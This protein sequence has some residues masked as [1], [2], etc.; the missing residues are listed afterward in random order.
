MFNEFKQFLLRGN[1]V[2]MGVGV[3]M[4]VAFKSVVDG[5]VKDMITP[6]IAAVAGEADFSALLF[7]LNGSQFLYGHLINVVVSF[8]ITAVVVFYLV[9]KPMNHF[10]VRYRDE[11]VPTAPTMHKCSFCRQEIAIAATRCPFCT[12]EV[13][14]AA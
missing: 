11:E 14:T 10:M 5:L 1:V 9:V 13:A 6:M 7:T 12:S 4:G 3:V 8:L 2:E